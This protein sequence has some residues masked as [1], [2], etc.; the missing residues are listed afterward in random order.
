MIKAVILISNPHITVKYIYIR[1]NVL[2]SNVNIFNLII[3]LVMELAIFVNNN[4]N[5]LKLEEL[6][7]LSVQ[8]IVLNQIVNLQ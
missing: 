3:L 8:T 2:M 4:I 7:Y 1:E 6:N 5:C